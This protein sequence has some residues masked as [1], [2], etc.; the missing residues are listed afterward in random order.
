MILAEG[1]V[2][3][4]LGM[5]APVEN[6][7]LVEA[8][9]RK[10]HEYYNKLVEIERWKRSEVDKYWADRGGYSAK[11]EEMENLRGEARSLPKKSVERAAKY[12]AVDALREEL[13]ALRLA[14][15][16][17]AR[18]TP[19]ARRRVQRAKELRAE[20]RAK[21]RKL[22]APE[23]AKMLDAEPDCVAPRD[24]LRMEIAA[25]YAARGKSVSPMMMSRRLRKA[26]FKSSTDEI[27]QEAKRRDYA[28]Y[29]E[30][31][32][33]PGT[34]ACVVSRLE[35]AIEDTKH[36][37]PA[38]QRWS[39]AA[40]SLGVSFR[41]VDD[42]RV[43]ELFSGRSNH[44]RIE[45]VPDS[46]N[47]KPGS[48]RSGR[49]ARLWLRIASREDRT[50]VWAVFP[51]WLERSPLPMDARVTAIRVKRERVGVH[52]RW[53][54]IIGVS[55]AAGASRV[56]SGEARGV[57]AFD[58]T[59]R[60]LAN[61]R[62]RAAYWCD[63]KGEHGSIEVPDSTVQAL[64]KTGDLRELMSR[65]LHWS[66]KAEEG[67]PAEEGGIVVDLAR[68]LRDRGDDLPSWLSK[69][70]P[71]VGKWR[72]AQRLNGLAEHWADN[73]FPGDED[74]YASLDEWRKRWRH[75]YEWAERGNA[76]ALAHR[77]E[78]YRMEIA[79]LVGRY[80]TVVVRD[81]DIAGMKLRKKRSSLV[82]IDDAIRAIMQLAAPGELR[83]TIANAA[84]RRGRLLVKLDDERLPTTCSM[85]GATC[86]WDRAAEIEHTCEH[87]GAHWDQHHNV[88]RNLL[89]VHRERF[90]GGEN[91]GGARDAA[92]PLKRKD[93][94]RGRSGD[95]ADAAE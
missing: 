1:S 81:L 82:K 4:R 91:T 2:S 6:G 71:H 66:V 26:G 79:R 40:V 28:A 63:D 12:E 67:Q 16:D 80:A 59:W 13:F 64:A 86:E 11:L 60:R 8:H 3:Y 46:P 95:A 47:V 76:S 23:L 34:R 30:S 62:I 68:W 94:S 22:R 78:H 56:T 57:V 5:L 31:G 93:K 24:R 43:A 74:M 88:A 90:G 15:E 51:L 41:K 9:M 92:K 25:E 19:E 61:G 7:E 52:D 33:S 70:T 18:D 27:E 48:R 77:T 35:R 10:A 89:A 42:L 29:E 84:K 75:L 17:K 20:A 69:V 83:E 65:M 50:P 38:F 32:I 53:I 49:R 21:G 58:L 55:L 36:N 72:S 54:A 14:E 85:C 39:E 73:R 45:R 37:P 87:C 44:A